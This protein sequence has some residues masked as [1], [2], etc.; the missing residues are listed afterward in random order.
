MTKNIFRLV[1]IGFLCCQA[2]VLAAQNFEGQIN[3][4]YR[5]SKDTIFYSAF[6]KNH[7]IR[8]NAFDS[9]R[10][11]INSLIINIE[12]GEVTALNSQRKIYRHLPPPRLKIPATQS[13]AIQKT[14]TKK[15]IQDYTCQQWQIK[16]TSNHTK[17]TF[18]VA[19]GPFHF[20]SELLKYFYFSEQ[21][22]LNYLNV[23]GNINYLPLET[24]IRDF[25]NNLIMHLEVS[26]IKQGTVTDMHFEIPSSFKSYY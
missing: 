19:K 18:W 7:N 20:F 16:Q 25:Q 24:Y 11:A 2:T 3:F 22:I 10:K 9:N 8:L 23:P 1:F 17:I 6:V 12:S 14:N 5:S 15:T 26:F 4:I 13:S 21:D